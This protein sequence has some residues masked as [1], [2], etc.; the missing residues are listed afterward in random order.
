MTDYKIELKWFSHKLYPFFDFKKTR[1]ILLCIFDF[2]TD[3]F[4]NDLIER[5]SPTVLKKD[6]PAQLQTI[7]YSL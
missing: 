2:S 5:I 1:L 3:S 4:E 6:I 7:L